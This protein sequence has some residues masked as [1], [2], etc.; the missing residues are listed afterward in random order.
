[1]TRSYSKPHPDSVYNRIDFPIGFDPG[2]LVVPEA[3]NNRGISPEFFIEKHEREP[4]IDED[5][6]VGEPRDHQPA[7]AASHPMIL[8]VSRG[9]RILR[10]LQHHF[11]MRRT[12]SES[13]L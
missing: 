9:A 11:S 3:V 13:E 2:Q 1:M 6:K 5:G 12:G 8:A 10:L 4:L 7:Q